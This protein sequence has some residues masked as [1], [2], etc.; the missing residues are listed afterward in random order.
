MNFTVQEYK[1]NKSIRSLVCYPINYYKGI[2]ED[3]DT[4]GKVENPEELKQA[5]IRRGRRF[6]ELCLKKQG[7]Q[8]FEY[9]GFAFSSGPRTRRHF[10]GAV[11]VKS[12][13]DT[14]GSILMS[15]GRR[16]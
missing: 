16:Y 2:S 4:F 7:S 11:Q 8:L 12:L 14:R 10:S 6:R 13:V 5:L 15:L 1:G 3:D 9:D